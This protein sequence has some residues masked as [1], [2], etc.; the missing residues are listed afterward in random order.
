MSQLGFPFV[1]RWRA[2]RE[3]YRPAGEVIAT[4]RFDVDRFADDRI[5]KAFVLEHHYSG[6]YPAAR[7]R[8][9]LYRSGAL[10]G[11]AVFSVPVS[12]KVITAPFK[13]PAIEGAELG[14]FVLLDDVGAN[15]ETWFLARCFEALRGELRGVVSH[16]DPV[17]R[18]TSAGVQV[19][20]GHVGTIYQAF[21][22][23]YLGRATA[24]T[25]RLLPD[26]R[27]FSPRAEQKIRSR[28]RG[29]RY[30]AAVLER[31]GAAPL[32]ERDDARAWLALWLPRLTRPLRHPG[33][34]RYV[35]ALD[36]W[37]RRELPPGKA[38]P[39]VLG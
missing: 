13:I 8:F 35:W 21:N 4:R 19:L 39:K 34:H 11:V 7:F 2:R 16:S 20:P 25:L 38:F 27:A 32:G 26:G 22:G 18:A 6:S 30:A 28:S 17:P 29:W 31:A 15:G 3:S 24:R 5:P 23:R 9:G 14:R 10:V 33:N 12:D 1:Q 37:L 36:R